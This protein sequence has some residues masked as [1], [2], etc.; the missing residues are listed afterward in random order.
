MT[1]NK[2]FTKLTA[3]IPSA[4]IDFVD[5][6][7]SKGKF[8][9]RTDAAREAFRCLRRDVE[10][11]KKTGVKQASAIASSCSSATEA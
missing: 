10:G 1:D 5:R 9:S 7:V 11:T 8:A 3:N 4:D 6:L 2:P